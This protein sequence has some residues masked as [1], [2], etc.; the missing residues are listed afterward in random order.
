MTLAQLEYII[1][2]DTWRHFATAAAKC[3]VI[4]PTLSLQIQKVEE[5]LG[6]RLFDRSEVPVVPTVEGMEII[7]QG[8]MALKEVE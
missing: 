3:F 4:Q 8:R 1:A 6:V 2:V 7:Q 5:E